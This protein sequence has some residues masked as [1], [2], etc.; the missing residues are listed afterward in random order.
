VNAELLAEDARYGVCYV[1]ASWPM[2]GGTSHS[3]R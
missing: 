3:E 1:V 2:S